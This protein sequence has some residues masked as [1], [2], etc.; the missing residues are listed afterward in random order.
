MD[1]LHKIVKVVDYERWK[2][3]GVAVGLALAFSVVSCAP[4]TVSI[5]NPPEKV[6]AA[7]IEREVALIEGDYATKLKQAELAQADLAKQYAM[8]KQLIEAAGGIATLA[9]TGGTVTPGALIGTI[10]Q[11]GLA[12]LALGAIG[13]KRRA[14]KIIANGNAKA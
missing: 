4:K 7:Q 13:D 14:N 10:T 3:I 8:R 6:G 2:V 1:V 11:L 9:A 12:G 5:L